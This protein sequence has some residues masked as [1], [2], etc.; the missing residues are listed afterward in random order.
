W[1]GFETRTASDGSFRIEAPPP[2]AEIVTLRVEPDRFH[3][4]FGVSFGSRNAESVPRLTAG[5]RDVGEPRLGIT[6][7]I[8]GRVTDTAGRPLADVRITIGS[9]RTSTLGH[10]AFTEPDGTYV[11]AHAPLGTYGANAKVD[12]HLANRVESV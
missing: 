12:G 6:G 10:E 5:V 11:L 9:S 3:D 7:A 4:S 2:T 8:S 1:H